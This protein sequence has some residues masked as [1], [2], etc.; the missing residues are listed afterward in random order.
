MIISNSE[1]EVFQKCEMRFYFQ[2]VLGVRPKEFPPAL[3][4]G[5]FGHR[6]LERYWTLWLQGLPQDEIVKEVSAM[7]LEVQHKPHLGKILRHA[8]AFADH[9]LNVMHLHPV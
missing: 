9:M 2:S 4:T 6:L 5:I 1:I 8:M 3:E 7:I